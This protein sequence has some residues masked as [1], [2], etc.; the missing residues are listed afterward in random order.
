MPGYYWP[1][2]NEPF[3]IVKYPNG[4]YCLYVSVEGAH[5]VEVT[6]GGSGVVIEPEYK[7]AIKE[8][9]G[10]VQSD[11]NQNDETKPDYVKNRPFYEA[12][13]AETVVE[14]TV[15]FAHDDGESIHGSLPANAPLV[16]GSTYR[17][18]FNDEEYECVAYHPQEEGEGGRVLAD[19][20]VIGNSVHLSDVPSI[21]TMG[22]GEPFAIV[23]YADDLSLYVSVE[24]DYGV[25]VIGKGE[26][27]VIKPEYKEAIKKSF[28]TIEMTATLEDGT[29]QT[30]KLYGEAV[31]E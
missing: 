19:Y 24:D 25:E 27:V 7:E 30:F 22:N 11:W 3:A 5:E 4:T 29:K 20:I 10:G 9:A 2:N 14:S 6:R 21:A 12:D 31:S 28:P 1:E 26:T 15:T 23:Q 16:V 17:V 13:E 8:A 18:M